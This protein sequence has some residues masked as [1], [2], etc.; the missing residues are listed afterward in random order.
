MIVV[1][2]VVMISIVFIWD[3]FNAPN[4]IASSIMRLLTNGKIKQVELK[5]PFGCSACMTFWITLVILLIGSPEWC[6]MSLVY[7]FLT[8]HTLIII[9]TIDKIIVKIFILIQKLL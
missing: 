3:W 6:W 2:L 8:K 7:A 1:C 5:K 9:D 4:E